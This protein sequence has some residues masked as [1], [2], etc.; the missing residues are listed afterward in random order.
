ML[1]ALKRDGALDLQGVVGHF[2]VQV[3]GDDI[4]VAGRRLAMLRNQTVGEK[5]LS[6]ADFAAAA[7]EV[8]LFAI[9]AGSGLKAYCRQLEA[10]GDRYSAFMAKVIADRLTEALAAE[11]VPAKEGERHAFGYPSCPDHSLKADV[12]EI[13]Q[14]PE[15]CDMRL[16]SSYMINPAESLCGILVPGATYFAVGRIAPDQLASYASRR[17]LPEEVLKSILTR[18]IL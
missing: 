5:N 14:V 15:S 1:E 6:L 11:V 12:F 8:T 17:N 4:L 7:G 3:D 10:S 18:N 2:P 9:C 16:T 13:L